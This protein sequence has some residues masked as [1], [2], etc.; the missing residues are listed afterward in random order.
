MKKNQRKRA[1][2]ATSESQLTR[3]E[4]LLAQLVLHSLGDAGQKKKA[5]A[6][7]AA[8]FS[9]IEIAQ[10][11]GIRAD[12]VAVVLYQARKE[13]RTGTARKKTSNKPSKR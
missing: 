5:L 8:G 12:A 6:L 2:K 1:S 9:N 3:T 13:R 10:T 7:R 11:M 4:G